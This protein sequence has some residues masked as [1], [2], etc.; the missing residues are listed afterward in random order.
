MAVSGGIIYFVNMKMRVFVSYRIVLYV[1]CRAI[2]VLHALETKS[3]FVVPF[4]FCTFT[5]PMLCEAGR[6]W[7]TYCPLSLVCCS[8]GGLW[9]LLLCRSLFPLF[10]WCSLYVRRAVP[11]CFHFVYQMLNLMSGE[12]KRD[13]KEDNPKDDALTN[14][15][16][17]LKVRLKA[18]TAVD[19]IATAQGHHYDLPLVVKSVGDCTTTTCYGERDCEVCGFCLADSSVAAHTTAPPPPSFS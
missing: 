9:V 13:L 19:P 11:L 6:P 4:G 8:E 15:Y 16:N 14:T 1:I 18:C 2:G 3:P 10:L 7:P 12:V 17:A 5:I